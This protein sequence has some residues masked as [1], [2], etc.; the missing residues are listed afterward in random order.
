MLHVHLFLLDAGAWVRDTLAWGSATSPAA[1]APPTW[2]LTGA[3]RRG[4]NKIGVSCSRKPSSSKR[5]GGRDKTSEAPSITLL[6]RALTAEVA[7]GADTV[8]GNPRESC[9]DPAAFNLAL[10][11]VRG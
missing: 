10:S 9:G 11:G 6:R 8:A 5:G 2:R 3:G 4:F 7:F 1:A